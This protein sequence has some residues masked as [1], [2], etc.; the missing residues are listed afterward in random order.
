MLNEFDT[1]AALG[2]RADIGIKAG[3]VG[4]IIAVLADGVFEVE[5]VDLD[6]QTYAS[7]AFKTTELLKLHNR[8]RAA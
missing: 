1:V 8:A 3:E 2:D 5:F 4:A 7:G 6:G